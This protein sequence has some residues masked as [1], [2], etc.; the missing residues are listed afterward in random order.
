MS[1]SEIMESTGLDRESARPAGDRSYSEPF[2]V[3]GDETEVETVIN[4]IKEK[5]YAHTQ[6]S[7]FHHILGNNDKGKAVKTVT[8]LYKKETPLVKTIGIGDSLND[9]PMLKAVDFP[10]QVMKKSGIYEKRLRLDNVML[11]DVEG[12]VG[13]NSAILKFFINYEGKATSQNRN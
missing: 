10:V 9:L 13:F 4:K 12:P 11:T 5:G 2:L 1:I 8:E 3:D 6:G 7:R